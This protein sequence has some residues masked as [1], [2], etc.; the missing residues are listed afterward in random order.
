MSL[1]LGFSVIGLYDYLLQFVGF[2]KERCTN[3]GEQ[4]V[5]DK[6]P[7]RRLDDK[8]RNA[9]RRFSNWQADAARNIRRRSFRKIVGTEPVVSRQTLESY[10]DLDRQLA[11]LQ[12]IGHDNRR[13]NGY[14]SHAPQYVSS[15]RLQPTL[16]LAR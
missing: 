13:L 8:F 14:S 5:V 12:Q 10:L 2:I 9:K 11:S 15:Y 4:P 3:D 16:P 1:W 7:Q 6:V